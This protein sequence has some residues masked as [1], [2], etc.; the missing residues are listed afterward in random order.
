MTRGGG[1]ELAVDDHGG[2]VS[3]RQREKEHS[4]PAEMAAVQASATMAE[5]SRCQVRFRSSV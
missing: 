5:V 4:P 2:P 1:G 3:V